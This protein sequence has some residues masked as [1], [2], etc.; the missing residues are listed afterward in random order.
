LEKSSNARFYGGL[1]ILIKNN[2]RP[3]MKILM[4]TNKDYQWLKLD[5]QFFFYF[6]KDIFL[7]WNKI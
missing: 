5:K 2:L 4:N 7:C 3:E 1:G 6:S